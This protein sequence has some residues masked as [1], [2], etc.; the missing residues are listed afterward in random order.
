VW[1]VPGFSAHRELKSYVD[2]GLTAYQALE[3]GTVNVARFFDTG[4]EAGTIAVGKNADFVL[5]DGNPLDDISNTTRQAGVMLRG[6]WLPRAE[7]E[8][9]LR[10]I[11]ARYRE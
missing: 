8:Q 9:R 7:I 10:E 5:L 2:A 3:T 4:I 1:N 11:A 6:L